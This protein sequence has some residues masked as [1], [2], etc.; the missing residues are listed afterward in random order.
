M[1]GWAGRTWAL[2]AEEGDVRLPEAVG[3]QHARRAQGERRQ[4]G[5][6]AELR[7]ELVHV[8]AVIDAVRELAPEQPVAR[9]RAR[10]RDLG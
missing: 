3:D 1:D 9:R 8:V 5:R 2:E 7:G 4:G 10:A 6:A